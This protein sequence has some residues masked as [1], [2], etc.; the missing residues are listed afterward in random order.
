MT[1]IEAIETTIAVRDEIGRDE[2]KTSQKREQ[3]RSA[4]AL[5]CN[6]AKDILNGVSVVDIRK[7]E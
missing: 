4:L 3:E 2:T 5:L 7:Q 6:C 1:I